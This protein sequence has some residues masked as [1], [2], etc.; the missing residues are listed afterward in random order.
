MHEYKP[1]MDKYKIVY[2]ALVYVTSFGS[3][4]R[5]IEKEYGVPHSTLED[6]FHKALPE[7]DTRLAKIVAKKMAVLHDKRCSNAWCISKSDS[8]A[9]SATKALSKFAKIY[10]GEISIRKSIGFMLWG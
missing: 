8:T 2:L 5:S 7:Y 4:L 10:R 1:K 6:Y 3:T 9:L